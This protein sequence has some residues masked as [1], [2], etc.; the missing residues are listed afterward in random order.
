[1]RRTLLDLTSNKLLVPPLQILHNLLAD[2]P[3]PRGAAG[4]AGGGP[5]CKS[6]KT[7]FKIFKKRKLQLGGNKLGWTQATKDY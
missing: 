4:G 2:R 5:P 3:A 1:M 7:T 6:K